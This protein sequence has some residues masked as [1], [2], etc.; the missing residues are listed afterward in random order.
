MGMTRWGYS[1]KPTPCL[2]LLFIPLFLS[3]HSLTV[4][5]ISGIVSFI[6]QENSFMLI[7]WIIF[8]ITAYVIRNIYLRLFF[9][10]YLWLLKKNG[11]SLFDKILLR[12]LKYSLLSFIII[13]LILFITQVFIE[14]N[15]FSGNFWFSFVFKFFYISLGLTIL[16]AYLIEKFVPESVFNNVEK[17]YSQIGPLMAEIEFKHS[18]FNNQH[19][20]KIIKN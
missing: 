14:N 7:F 4:I 3:F 19:N 18:I 9:N 1:G 12:S 20:K 10:F 6:L 15:S 2:S 8:I 17:A 13:P 16:M 11:K 5:I